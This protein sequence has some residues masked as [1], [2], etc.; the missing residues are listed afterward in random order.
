MDYGKLL[1]TAVEVATL[2]GEVIRGGF[3]KPKEITLKGFADPVTQFDKQSERVIVERILKEFPGHSI[4]TEEELSITGSSDFRWVIDPLDGTVNFTHRLPFVAVSIGVECDGRIVAGVIFNPITNEYYTASLGGGAYLNKRPIHVSQASEPGRSM[5]V[6]GFPY[7]REGRVEEVLKPL[8][9][10]VK[11]YEGFRRLGSAAMD[12]A[13]VAA[14][15]CDIFYEENLKP[16]DTAAGVILV[17]E[18]GGRVTDY[19][20]EPFELEKKTILATNGILHEGFIKVLSDVSIP[21]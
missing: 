1:G 7:K 13:Y 15:I 11:D 9:T 14:G 3:E 2:G 19:A 17:T 12:M 6:T 5:V 21:E 20:G 10:V 4:L 16:W 18:A 8:Q